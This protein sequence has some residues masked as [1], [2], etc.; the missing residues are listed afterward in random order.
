M[1]KIM[2]NI[3]NSS[4]NQN[5]SVVYCLVIANSNKTI[6]N[7]LWNTYS[8]TQDNNQRKFIIRNLGCTKNE[9]LLTVNIHIGMVLKM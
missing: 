1:C 9:E 3:N 4:F 8:M 6:W 5:N 7:Q 2:I